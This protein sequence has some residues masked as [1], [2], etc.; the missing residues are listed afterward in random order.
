MDILLPCTPDLIQN[1]ADNMRDADK[2][3]VAA[4]AGISPSAA[5]AQSVACSVSCVAWVVDGQ[6]ACM[7]GIAAPHILSTT[8]APWLLSSGVVPQNSRKFLRGTKLFITE[9]KKQY[10]HLGNFIDARYTVAIRW[11][12]WL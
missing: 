1:L 2:A 5:L 7:G 6:V 10:N 4:F 8:G 9:W 12:E 11:V 3:E